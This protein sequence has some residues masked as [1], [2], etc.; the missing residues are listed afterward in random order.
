MFTFDYRQKT[1][2]LI[3]FVA[4]CQPCKAHSADISW[5]GFG[6]TYY[7]QALNSAL[8]PDGFSDKHVDF[9]TFSLMGLNLGAKV[10]DDFSFAAQI[11]ALGDSVGTTD[12]FG[13]IAQWAYVNY[14]PVENTSLRAGRQLLPVLMASEFVRVGYLLPYRQIPSI[15]Y[16]LVPFSRFDG[17]SVYQT[18]DTDAGKLTVGAFG[19]KPALDINS[20]L[21]PAGSDYEFDDLLGVQATLDGNG[22]RVRAQASRDYSLASSPGVSEDGHIQN[23]SVGYRF[24]KYNIVSWGEYV[25]IRTPDGTPVNGGRYIGDGRGYYLLGGYRIGRFMPRYTFA[26][27]SQTFNVGAPTGSYGNGQVTSHTIGLNYQAGSQAV[28]KCEYELDLVP[29]AQG[30]GYLVTQPSNTTV[31]AGS[32]FYLGVDFIF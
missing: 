4:M 1:L 6:S 27:A 26:Q 10:N 7:G 23:Y 11:V 31:A 12:S 29:T 24:D 15:V 32:A 28:I 25:L 3:A 16:N 17:V 2:A 20:T 9:T 14:T 30:G 5:S 22:W 21:L 18:I 8:F 13:L 19:G